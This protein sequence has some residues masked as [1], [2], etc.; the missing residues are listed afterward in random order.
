MKKHSKANPIALG[1]GIL[2]IFPPLEMSRLLKDFLR[3][4]G[5]LF[6]ETLG[7]GDIFIEDLANKQTNP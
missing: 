3:K 6:C 7:R 5:C 2:S 4:N 1:N